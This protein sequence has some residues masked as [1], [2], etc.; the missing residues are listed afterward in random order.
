M[1]FADMGQGVGD[2]SAIQI[3]A[4]LSIVSRSAT[5]PVECVHA[6]TYLSRKGVMAVAG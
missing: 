5:Y 3:S 6:D 1:R 4:H 2:M